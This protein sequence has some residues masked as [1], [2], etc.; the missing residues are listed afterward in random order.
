[1]LRQE[2]W[3][4]EPNR[5]SGSPKTMNVPEFGEFSLSVATDTSP[6]SNDQ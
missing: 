1:M 4:L 3:G 2:V 6:A 5:V